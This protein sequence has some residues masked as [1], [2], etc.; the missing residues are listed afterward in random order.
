MPNSVKMRES[1]FTKNNG[2]KKLSKNGSPDS[3]LPISPDKIWGKAAGI[4]NIKL[5]KK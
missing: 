4:T 5:H 3:L 1:G 2:V